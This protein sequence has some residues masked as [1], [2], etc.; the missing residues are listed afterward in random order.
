MTAATAPRTRPVL[1]VA[2]V[3]ALAACGET[4]DPEA[5]PGSLVSPQVATVLIEGGT[6]HTNADNDPNQD[7][8][9]RVLAVGTDGQVLGLGQTREDVAHLLAGDPV[10]I[11]LG[12]AVA[13]PGF[14]DSHMHLQGVG[15][16]ELT[17]N[18]EGVTGIA[19]QIGR[20]H[21]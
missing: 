18:L 13:Y 2:M 1:V 16:R 5:D 4:P 19:D 21:V 9:V 14:T 8:V 17:L 10:V 7:P 15:E 6:I 3:I 11:D 12:G 20:A